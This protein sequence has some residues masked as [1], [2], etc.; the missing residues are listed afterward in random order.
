MLLAGASRRANG[1]LNQVDIE[2]AIQ[3]ETNPEIKRLLGEVSKIKRFAESHLYLRPSENYSAYYDTDQEGITFVVTASKRDRLVP[4]TWWFPIIGNVAYKG[5]F[6]KEDAL[7]LEKELKKEGYDT[8]VFVAPAYSSLGW[9]KDPITTPMLRKG[10]YNLAYTIIHEMTHLTIYVGGQSD[11]NEQLAVF[12]GHIGALQYFKSLNYKPDFFQGIKQRQ[13]RRIQ[14]SKVMQ[15]Y[16][17]QLKALYQET[18]AFEEILRKREQIF[19]KLTAE[20]LTISPQTNK[21]QW[22]F[23]NARLLQYRRY[24]PTNPLMLRFWRE[25]GENWRKFWF[26]LSQHIEDQGW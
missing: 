26:R 21:E 22:Q 17:A 18:Q 15:K 14:F 13:N 9:F 8:W 12:V 19:S 24:Q 10:L 16:I 11:F 23:N 5:F 1:R 4:Y 7:E 25:E 6:D 2:E 20:I 3:N